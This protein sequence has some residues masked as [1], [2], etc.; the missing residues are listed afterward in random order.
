SYWIGPDQTLSDSAPLHYNP[1][2][3]QTGS[4]CFC[5][6][7]IVALNYLSDQVIKIRV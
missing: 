2:T 3:C 4:H 6:K 1:L 5:P 7:L